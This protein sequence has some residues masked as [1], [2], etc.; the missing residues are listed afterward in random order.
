A[1]IATEFGVD[2]RKIGGPLFIGHVND[3]LRSEQH[4]VA[5]VAARLGGVEARDAALEP[6]MR[7]V[8]R[9]AGVVVLAGPGRAFIERHN[10]IGPDAALNIHHA[11]G[12]KQVLRAVDVRAKG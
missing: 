9:A 5:S 8:Q 11:L 10:N 12:R 3:A 4:A 7:H 2:G 6:A 1:G